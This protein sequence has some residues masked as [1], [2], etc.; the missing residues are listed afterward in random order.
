MDPTSGS[1]LQRINHLETIIH[2]P[3]DNSL[4]V[5]YVV[6]AAIISVP[7]INDNTNI[8][9]LAESIVNQNSQILVPS[10]KQLVEVQLYNLLK[11]KQQKT[12]GR[13]NKTRGSS[14][15]NKA[16]KKNSKSSRIARIDELDE[17]F[18][19][20]YDNDP[21][22]QNANAKLILE[23]AQ[24]PDNLPTIVQHTNLMNA[25][26]RLL[27]DK[28]S[29]NSELALNIVFIYFCISHFDNF[30][31]VLIPYKI[32]DVT[33]NLIDE[34]LRKTNKV[35]HELRKDRIKL[36]SGELER[37]DQIQ[38]ESRIKQNEKKLGNILDKQSMLLYASFHLL[39]N[40][41]DA[42]GEEQKMISFDLIKHLTS[43]MD[44]THAELVYLAI[45][46]LK[47]LSV[48][49][50]G[51]QVLAESDILKKL[52]PHLTNP[53][54]DIIL[55]ASLRLLLNLCFIPQL[56]TK[57]AR[58]NVIISSLATV[59]ERNTI[60][61]STGEGVEQA[62]L[63]LGILS[64]ESGQT[65]C[66]GCPS[67]VPTVLMF[68]FSHSEPSITFHIE[69]CAFLLSLSVI[70]NTA[71]LI[72]EGED[73]RALLHI[74]NESLSSGSHHLL[75][76][77]Q[78]ISQHSHPT[79]SSQIA[80]IIPAFL[81]FIQQLMNAF[82][83][84]T[85]AK[86]K[87]SRSGSSQAKRD[88]LVKLFPVLG[89]KLTRQQA[90]QRG[91]LLPDLLD[92]IVSTNSSTVNFGEL[93]LNH[94]L[95]PIFARITNLTEKGNL[96]SS[97]QD[98]EDNVAAE[99]IHGIL[100]LVLKLT[101]IPEVLPALAQS[102]W[103]SLL[104]RLIEHHWQDEDIFDICL[105]ALHNLLLHKRTRDIVIL[106]SE[107][108]VKFSLSLVYDAPNPEQRRIADEIL[109]IIA[110]ADEK[111]GAVILDKKF[112]IYN[113]QWLLAIKEHERETNG[114]F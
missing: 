86:D 66:T 59:L 87:K 92:M 56:R 4:I 65:M 111:L 20:L 93:A 49:P 39:H 106:H 64:E 101:S 112:E 81:Q 24:T 69:A 68:I 103:V 63:V 42:P 110:A 89:E 78:Q 53:Q 114:H 97:E 48:N 107:A 27:E 50:G 51:M 10:V 16:M 34:E 45:V 13:L 102:G 83:R 41:A 77:L 113:K 26:K 14:A 22:V 32:T 40:L 54:T 109:F 76:L 99:V 79:I 71:L 62:L 3:T 95:L 91:S 72:A 85:S 5:H 98:E 47:R 52:R 6:E 31:P 94:D 38:L 104:S 46:F 29:R 105:A 58:D 43:S 21:A 9:A 28:T 30:H 15:M 33:I 11:A 12:R 1:S 7:P 61:D 25:L 57:I 74:G 100:N 35:Q 96:F 80:I 44:M 18:D 90:D 60:E 55:D 8:P 70:P 84:D 88:Q 73:G 23:L 19:R 75:L 108:L 17:Y 67:L 82:I 2:D 37:K 36:D